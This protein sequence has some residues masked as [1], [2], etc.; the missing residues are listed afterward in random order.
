MLINMKTDTFISNFS[1]KAHIQAQK[2]YRL[3]I[4]ESVWECGYNHGTISK[5]VIL[6]S[7]ILGA[8]LLGAAPAALI[9]FGSSTWLVPAAGALLTLISA[10][11]LKAF[12]L[13]CPSAY[14]MKTRSFEPAAYG[15]GRLY[16]QGDI[17]I[18]ELKNDDPYRA[19]EAHGYLLGKKLQ[20]MLKALNSVNQSRF[21]PRGT[22]TPALIPRALKELRAQIPQEFLDEMQGI[23]D[24]YN[25]WDREKNGKGANKIT[26]DDLVLIHMMPDSI[27]FKG[28]HQTGKLTSTLGCTVAIDKD[29]KEGFVFGRNM[30]WPSLNLFGSLTL[31]I[32]R[33]HSDSKQSTVEVGLPGFAG[34][35]TGMN[36]SGLSIAMNVCNGDTR[37]IEGMPAVFFNRL[38][39]ENC[40]TVQD[41]AAQIAKKPPLGDYHLSAADQHRAMAFHFKQGDARKH[42]V[43]EWSKEKPLVVTNCRYKTDGC[44]EAKSYRFFSKEREELFGRLFKEARQ[45]LAPQ[46]LAV[47]KLIAAGL[48]LPYIN[49]P[50]TTHKVVMLPQSRKMSVAFDNAFAGKRSLLEIDTSPLLH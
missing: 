32:N 42:A 4:F 26:L 12:P 15:A 10:L 30:D 6:A 33:R 43:R 13:L 24:G 23:V 22:P 48:A 38:C 18:L 16:Y 27:H 31:I 37:K 40:K 28:Y 35:L 34:T 50:L 25:K 9:F 49:N 11:A 3:R 45:T 20:N 44:V 7:F 1:Y 47:D 8:T 36:K 14:S 46:E 39:L 19:G 17:P 21:N 41:V 5:T 2:D 29:A